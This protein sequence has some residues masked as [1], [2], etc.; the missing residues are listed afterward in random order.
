M[1]RDF[2]AINKKENKVEIS[3]FYRDCK[4]LFDR[5]NYLIDS[6]DGLWCQEPDPIGA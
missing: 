3:T 1:R 5:V 2:V 4:K 6:F